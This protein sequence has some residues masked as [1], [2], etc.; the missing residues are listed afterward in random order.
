MAKRVMIVGLRAGLVDAFRRQLELPDVELL[1][2]TGVEDI[3]SAFADADIDHVFL[4]GGLDLETRS[5]AVAEIF[6]SSDRATVHLKDHLSGPEG[7]VP[8]VR[9]VLHGLDDYEPVAS[10]H[11]V[12]RSDRAAGT[13]SA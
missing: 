6:R 4:G 5:A 1:A 9:A 11:A 2:G 7:F 8:F 13:G 12:L 10:E 3:R